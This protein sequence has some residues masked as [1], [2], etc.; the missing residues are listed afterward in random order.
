MPSSLP[1]LTT[2]LVDHLAPSLD[3]NQRRFAVEYVLK[4]VTSDTKGST[5]R[6]WTDIAST[7]ELAQRSARVRVQDDLA[8][9]L[10]R[11]LGVLEVHKGR[12]KGWEGD[13]PIQVSRRIEGW[14]GDR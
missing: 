7:L 2:Q 10:E 6:E 1:D 11:C 9:A 14:T 3:P 5:R 13:M 4:E 12:V 8:D